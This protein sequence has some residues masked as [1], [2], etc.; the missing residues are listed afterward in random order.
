MRVTTTVTVYPDGI[1]E[2]DVP[3]DRADLLELERRLKQPLEID[4]VEFLDDR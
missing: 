4:Y 1:M 3:D 2:K